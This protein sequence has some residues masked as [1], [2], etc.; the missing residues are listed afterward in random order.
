MIN[1]MDAF[2]AYKKFL[3]IKLHFKSEKYDY[4]KYRGSVNATRTSFEVRNDKYHFHKLSKKPNL[5]LFLACNIRDD[6]DVWVGNL[7]DD[8]HL[9]NFRESQ[10]RMQSLEYLFKTDMQKYDSLDDALVVRNG[11]YPKILNDFNRGDTMAE[12][13]IILN[14]TCNVFEYWDSQISDQ[15][16]WP[17]IKQ[18]LLK[19]T[20]FLN[21]DKVKFNKI[22]KEM[23]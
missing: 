18:K 14:D 5:E 4:F 3:A 15:I 2:D 22:L 6:N 17:R 19:Y 7:F 11:E 13:M 10:K 1:V 8:K 23:M 21:V 9:S 12:T 16:L 20:G